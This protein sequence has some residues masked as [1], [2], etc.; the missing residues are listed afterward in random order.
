MNAFTYK[1]RVKRSRGKWRVSVP[2]LPSDAPVLRVTKL[3]NASI[4]MCEAVG[5][6]L[7]VSMQVVNVI[8]EHPTRPARKS[9]RARVTATAAQVYGGVGALAGVYLAAGLAATLIAAGIGVTALATLRE[10]GKI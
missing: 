1:T 4:M 6:Y 10:M 3:E 7:G 8:V 2:E 5:N 9:L